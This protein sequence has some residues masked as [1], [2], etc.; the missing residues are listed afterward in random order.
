[1]NL[2]KQYIEQQGSIPPVA[3]RCGGQA[4]RMAIVNVEAP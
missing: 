4:K 2:H 3:E 1:M